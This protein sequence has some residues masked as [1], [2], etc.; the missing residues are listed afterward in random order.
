MG[1]GEGS[2]SSPARRSRPSSGLGSGLSRTEPA[3]RVEDTPEPPKSQTASVATQTLSFAP[4]SI[5][6][7][8][9]PVIV[10]EPAQHTQRTTIPEPQTSPRR[11]HQTPSYSD[12]DSAQSPRKSKRLSRREREREEELRRNL[13]REIEEELR[14]VKEPDA[15]DAPVAQARYPSRALTN[16]ELNAVI[17]SE[18]FVDFVERSSKVI[19]K[20]LDQ[21]YD[22]LVDYGLEGVEGLNEEE[23]EGYAS[24]KGRRGRRM[25]EVAQFYDE[26]WSKKRM[27]SDLGFSPKV[28][29]SRR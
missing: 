6:Y 24:S 16:E 29:L 1:P 10:T 22:V 7:E 21:D 20:T 28:R 17:A 18:D 14:A 3:E 27:I 19:E 2:T 8:F 25:K 26:R 4:L 11:K 23:D 13:R 9:A 12:S 5:N 15:A